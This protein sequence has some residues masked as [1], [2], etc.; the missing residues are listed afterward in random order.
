MAQLGLTASAAGAA[1]ALATALS[2]RDSTTEATP[3][4][5]FQLA[6][7]RAQDSSPNAWRTVWT[8]DESALDTWS[9]V[10]NV[11]NS[12]VH[13]WWVAARAHTAAVATWHTYYETGTNSD[14]LTVGSMTVSNV[15]TGSPSNGK[16]D[17]AGSGSWSSNTASNAATTAAE[18]QTACENTT[19]G[20][21]IVNPD[22]T[23][24]SDSAT[25]T[26]NNGGATMANFANGAQSANY[27]AGYSFDN[28]EA[29]ATSKCKL[30]LGTTTGLQSANDDNASSLCGKYE[31]SELGQFVTN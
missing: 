12:K 7:S 1:K 22:T 10:S 13:V 14:E 21:L 17:V 18:C 30:M 9:A 19:V 3:G 2:A 26:A 8:L 23:N 29:T 4:S 25:T 31:A 15:Q 5:G 11:A 6:S 20:A 27:C 16:C 28:A 24:G